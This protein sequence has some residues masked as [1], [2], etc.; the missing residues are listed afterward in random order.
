[1][2]IGPGEVKAFDNV[3]PSL[4]NVTNSGAFYLLELG[5]NQTF[6]PLYGQGRQR[7]V[8]RAAQISVRFV[9]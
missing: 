4:F 1:V 6:S 3:L 8:P 7:Q 2:T 5:A 9:F